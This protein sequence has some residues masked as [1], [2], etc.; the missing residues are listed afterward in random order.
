MPT[1]TKR[2][3]DISILEPLKDF[4][5][6]GSGGQGGLSP[7]AWL[8]KVAS[9]TLE[10][11]LPGHV[12]QLSLVITDDETLRCLN[13]EYRGLD[14]VTDVLSFSPFHQGHWEGAEEPPPS[15][16]DVP[17]VLPPEEPQPLG[18]VIISYPQAM[19]QSGPGPLGPERE[20]ALLVVHGVLHLLGFDHA[21]PHEEVAMQAQEREVLSTIFSEASE[22]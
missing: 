5:V 6:N 9:R 2:R 1:R 18:E 21:E 8:R 14:E 20:L 10:H 17:F 4:A 15:G 19:R 7:R 3:V 13:K 16:D 22:Q 12:C 11:A